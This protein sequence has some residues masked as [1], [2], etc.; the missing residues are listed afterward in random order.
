MKKGILWLVFQLIIIFSFAQTKSYCYSLSSGELYK[1]NLYESSEAS[2]KAVY[3]LYDKN[4]YLLKSLKGTY[5]ILDEGVY[6]PARK[7]IADFNGYQVKW[8]ILYNTEGEAQSIQDEIKNTI[9][10]KCY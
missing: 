2:S 5:S 10:D 3:N 8:L 7:I 1:L 9:W 6:S 4:G